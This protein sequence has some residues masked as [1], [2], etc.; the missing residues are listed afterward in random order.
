MAVSAGRCTRKGPFVPRQVVIA[1]TGVPEA[2]AAQRPEV[3]P[4]H[5]KGGAAPRG[6]RTP[7]CTS[8]RNTGHPRIG[9][10]MARIAFI[11]DDTF[12]DSEFRIPFDR[13]TQAG[14]DC[15]V[16]S[17]EGKKQVKGKKGEEV[18]TPDR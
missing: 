6:D 7:E 10:I 18:V 8:R 16:I 14:F 13:L 1:G 9:G 2:A 12:E 4:A 3:L 5:G 15:V 11:L 17:S